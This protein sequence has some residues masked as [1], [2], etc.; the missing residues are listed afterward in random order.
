MLAAA[1]D[2]PMRL[3]GPPTSLLRWHLKTEAQLPAGLSGDLDLIHPHQPRLLIRRCFVVARDQDGG[4]EHPA[5]QLVVVGLLDAADPPAAA[6]P[7][8]FKA[9]GI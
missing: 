8:D 6:D 2:P 7:A 3:L 9:A 5:H 4:I 1:F